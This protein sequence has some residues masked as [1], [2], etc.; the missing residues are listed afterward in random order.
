M[1]GLVKNFTPIG[2]KR[3]ENSCSESE[4]LGRGW[5]RAPYVWVGASVGLKLKCGI[6]DKT[7]TKGRSAKA[8]F[9]PPDHYG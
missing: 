6:R 7:K 1:Y 2:L 4:E 8:S 5:E 3:E 9:P